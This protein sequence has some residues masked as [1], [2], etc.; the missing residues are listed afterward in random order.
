MYYVV[1]AQHDVRGQYNL[2]HWWFL[3][4][5]CSIYALR[6][7]LNSLAPL[8]GAETELKGKAVPPGWA[9][10]VSKEKLDEWTASGL[11]LK[12]ELERLSQEVTSIEYGNLMRKVWTPTLA[13]EQM[14]TVIMRP[15][16]S[17]CADKNLLMNL[18]TLCRC[19]ISWKNIG[20][21]STPP[22]EP[23]RYLNL[24]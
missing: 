12:S 5:M 9:E 22:S 16:D 7:L 23:F 11:E 13:L 15:S 20:S 18:S 3:T 1:S 4:F 10:D 14:L 24:P 19:W 17:P 21:I 6:A 2:S 8:I